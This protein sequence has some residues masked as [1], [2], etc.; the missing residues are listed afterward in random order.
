MVYCACIMLKIGMCT[1]NTHIVGA[2]WRCVIIFTHF[3]RS[4]DFS[5]FWG[6]FFQP[7]RVFFL[8]LNRGITQNEGWKRI[9][10]K[11]SH[12]ETYVYF[13]WGVTSFLFFWFWC[14]FDDFGG[15]STRFVAF[16]VPRTLTSEYPKHK[17]FGNNIKFLIFNCLCRWDGTPPFFGSL[18]PFFE[19]NIC[20]RKQK[21][22][23]IEHVWGKK[24]IGEGG[25][26]NNF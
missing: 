22:F 13:L 26:S 24:N 12:L 7:K 19:K 4:R 10:R 1:L 11:I 18:R 20:T 3:F 6:H 25:A 9:L 23:E 21:S 2:R 16:T 17:W 14:F 8:I 15:F 5:G